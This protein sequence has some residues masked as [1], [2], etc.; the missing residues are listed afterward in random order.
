MMRQ[1]IMVLNGEA[2]LLATIGLL[3]F[4]TACGP[5]GTEP[6]EEIPPV[7]ST[8]EVTSAS[9][10]VAFSDKADLNGEFAPTQT[11]T[12]VRGKETDE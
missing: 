8:Q 7:V 4:L 6:S 5:A 9:A 10:T 11:D 2:I 3:L 12:P 1:A